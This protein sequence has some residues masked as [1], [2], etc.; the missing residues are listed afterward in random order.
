MSQSLANMIAENNTH[1]FEG[2]EK[3]MEVWFTRKDGMTSNCDLR[4]IPR[5]Q[6][7]AVMQ[8][9]K[10]EIISTTSTEEIDAY[11]LSESSMFISARRFILKT[12][13]TTTPLCCLPVLISLVQEYAGYDH[14]QDLYYSRKNFKRPELQVS[15]HRTFEEEAS[16][17]D[18]FFPGGRAYCMGSVNRADCWYLYTVSPGRPRYRPNAARH[19]LPHNR[20]GKIHREPDQTLEVLMM[21]LD[22][23][24]MK[25]FYKNICPTAAEATKKSGIDRLIPE[26]MID[27]YQF[28]PCGYSMNGLMRSVPG[29]YMTIHITPEPEF[30]YVSF[31][32]NVP[33]KSYKDLIARVVA[34]FGPKQFVLTFFTSVESG[35]SIGIEDDSCSVPQYSDYD[36][37]DIQ[38]CRLQGYD[39]TYA[40]YNRFPS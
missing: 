40:L 6:L 25:W 15:P 29:G 19:N 35:A 12:C 28:E 11:L 16:I 2:V 10:C 30:S 13:G 39:L 27:D 36:V 5:S 3:L 31:E 33:Q 8:I 37:D 26:M 22:P 32:T 23:E 24:K 38:I 17:L 21:D 34:T 14:V 1:F 18:Q 20:I 7:E 4:K 9:V